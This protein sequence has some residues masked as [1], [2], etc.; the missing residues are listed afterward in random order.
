MKG[1]APKDLEIIYVGDPM[2]SWCW[3]FAPV[4]EKL[5]VDYRDIADLSLILGGLRPGDASTVMNDDNKAVMRSHWEKVEEVVRANHSITPFL[6]GKI[7]YTTRSQQ[8][9]PWLQ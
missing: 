5:L 8:Q 2:C 3:G 9:G 4:V 1:L 6:G 7:F